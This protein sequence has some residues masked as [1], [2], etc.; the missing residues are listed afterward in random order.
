MVKE[1]LTLSEVRE[2]LKLTAEA[3]RLV[4]DIGALEKKFLR[5]V[6]DDGYR[7]AGPYQV[8]HKTQRKRHT[9]WKQVCVDRL[10]QALVDELLKKA[11]L[12]K[13]SHSIVIKRRESIKE[14]RE[15]HNVPDHIPDEQIDD[16][17]YEKKGIH[18]QRKE[19]E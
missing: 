1:R 13:P 7:L 10:G 18:T 19:R 5:I 4:E 14:M 2:Y 8:C 15:A 16:Y 11:P 12:G 17:I 6:P 9:G 3:S